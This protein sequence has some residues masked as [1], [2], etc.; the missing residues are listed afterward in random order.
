MVFFSDDTF[1]IIQEKKQLFHS[2]NENPYL[3]LKS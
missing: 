2:G 1:G 3:S